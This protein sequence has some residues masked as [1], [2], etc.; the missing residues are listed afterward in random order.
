MDKTKKGVFGLVR[1]LQGQNI[2]VADNSARVDNLAFREAWNSRTFDVN[3]H[4]VP[5]VFRYCAWQ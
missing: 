1:Q 5:Y 2:V 4:H 3:G